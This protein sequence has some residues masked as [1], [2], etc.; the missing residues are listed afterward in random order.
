MWPSQSFTTPWEVPW[1]RYRSWELMAYG[2]TSWSADYN[3]I[4]PCSLVYSWCPLWIRPKVGCAVFSMGFWPWHLWPQKPPWPSTLRRDRGKCIESCHE[5]FLWCWGYMYMCKSCLLA[6]KIQ[7]CFDLMGRYDESV[8]QFAS[9]RMLFGRSIG[10]DS[11]L[12]GSACAS[13]TWN[14]RCLTCW[15]MLDLVKERCLVVNQELTWV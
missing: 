6:K 14:G 13:R 12:Y 10:A 3:K 1:N 8:D 15:R 9:A 7:G 5:S 4:A 11:P 2:G